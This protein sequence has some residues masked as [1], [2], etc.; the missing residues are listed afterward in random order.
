MNSSNDIRQAEKNW[1]LASD[2]EAVYQRVGTGWEGLRGGSLFITGA[3]G[4]IG[5]WLLETIRYADQQKDLGVSVTIL[6]RDEAAFQ[7]RCPHLASWN[8]IKVIS[9]DVKNFIFPDGKFTHIIHGA[10]EASAA[11]NISSP[12]TM[13]DTVVHGTRRVLDFAIDKKVLQVLNLS[14]GAV[15]GQQAP[16]IALVSETC[17]SGP[18]CTN[19]I[20]AY[21][22]SKRAAEMLGAIY[23]KQ[24]GLSF[25]SARIFAVLGPF[26][27]LDTHFAAGNFIRDAIEQRK[28][29]VQSDGRACRSYIYA[30]DLAAAVWL[31]AI[32]KPSSPAFNLGSENVVSIRDLAE[33][34]ATLLGS[35]GWEVLGRPDGGWNPG[36]YAPATSAFTEL[37]G[38]MESTTLQQ[39]IIR[40]AK[41][42]GW[43]GF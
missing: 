27:P 4:F 29:S 33:T 43:K 9:G 30:A 26:L 38:P 39:A 31:L 19:P 12:I 2:L 35:S 20:D 15:Y 21:A 36:R 42:N 3:T 16:D 24:F 25:C 14:S 34:V 22:E 5:R 10:T 40:T 1:S 32:G 23:A 11:L 7:R 28:I 6:T 17:R 8:S 18:S 13:F 37:F 41:W